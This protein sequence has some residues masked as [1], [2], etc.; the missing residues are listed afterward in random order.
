MKLGEVEIEGQFE[1][2]RHLRL[3]ADDMDV[4]ADDGVIGVNH[5]PTLPR[6]PGGG[7]RR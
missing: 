1:R 3:N 2:T 5:V 4:D 7:N 6:R